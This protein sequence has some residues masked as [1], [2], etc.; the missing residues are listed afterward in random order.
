MTTLRMREMNNLR[1]GALR[2]FSRLKAR[3]TGHHR[4][5]A[6]LSSSY[7]NENF[8]SYKRKQLTLLATLISLAGLDLARLAMI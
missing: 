4:L 2:H 8:R 5:F 3:Q 1:F 6:F 7:T